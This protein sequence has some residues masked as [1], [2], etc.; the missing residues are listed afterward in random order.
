[1][2]IYLWNGQTHTHTILSEE[3]KTSLDGREA[4]R[5]REERGGDEERVLERVSELRSW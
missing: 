2:S 5:R 3:R 4:L 1:M